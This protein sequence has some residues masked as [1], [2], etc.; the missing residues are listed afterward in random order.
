M[1]STQTP[2]RYLAGFQAELDACRHDLRQWSAEPT[3]E[4]RTSLMNR[5]LKLH[6]EV[7]TF[8][9]ESFRSK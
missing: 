9:K 4:E 7:S 3:P 6:A 1:L 2:R 8:R 5:V